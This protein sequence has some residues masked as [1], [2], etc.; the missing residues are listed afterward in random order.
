MPEKIVSSVK[1]RVSRI[2]HHVSRITFFILLISAFILLV[3]ACS[4]GNDASAQ[5]TTPTPLPAT[6]PTPTPTSP[7]PPPQVA[8]TPVATDTVSPIIVQRFPRRGEELQPDGSIELTF[9]RAM[10]Q[11][12]TAGAF[13]LQV[14]AAPPQKVD[15]QI[16]W[17]D[18]QGRTMRFTP[19]Q[20]LDRATVYDA[21]LTQSA[22]AEDGAPLAE[23]FTF[24]FSTPG[25]LEV[26]QVM[27]A[28]GTTNV[29]T[30]ATITVMFNRPVVA[31]TS[32]EQ[33]ENFP[34][35]LEFEPAVAGT[36]EWLNTSIYVFKPEKPMSGGT[37]FKVRVSPDLTDAAGQTVMAG[38][39]EWS[40][41]TQPPEVVFVSPTDG[42]TLVPI[43]TPVRVTFNQPVDPQS[44]EINFSLNAG[45]FFGGGGV[46]GQFQVVGETLTFTPT[47]RLEFDTTYQVTLA[48]GITSVAG[49]QGMVSP[50]TFSFTTVPLPK[51]VSTEPQNGERAAYPYTD[52]RITFNTPISPATVMPH[53]SMIP[54]L[55]I[56]PTEVYTY[57]SPWDNTFSIGF[58]AKPSTDYEVRIT[59]GIEDPY[60][61]KTQENLTVRFRTAPLPPTYQ[62]RIPDLI[63]TYDAG[64]AARMIVSYVNLTDLNLR[65]FRL[66]PLLIQRP[67]WE[68]NDFAPAGGDLVREWSERLEAAVDKQSFHTIDLVEGGGALEPGLY[69]LEADSPQ[70]PDDQYNDK[71]RHIMVVSET[72]LTLKTGQYDTLVW[73]TNLASG[74]PTPGLEVTFFDDERS[75]L[76]TATTDASGVARLDLGKRDNR[77]AIL[78]VVLPDAN[79]NGFTAVAENW[80]QGISPYDFGLNNVTYGLPQYTAHIYTDRPIY[81]PGQTV[82]FK[83]I[84]RTEDD[85]KFGRPDL[86]QVHLIVRN[87]NYETI[88]DQ[89]MEVSPAG[90]LNGEVKLEDGAALGSYAI[91]IDFDNQ[92]FE[93][94]FQ[95]SAYRAPEFE[96]TV[97]P[98]QTEAKRG[99]SIA[100]TI[101]TSY[102]FGGPLAGADVSWNILAESYRFD[103]AQLGGYSFDDTDDPYVCFDCWWWYQDSVPQPVLSGSGQSDASG[104]LLIEVDGPELDSLLT[105]GS[106]KI[107][108]EATATGLDNQV[109]SGRAEVILHKGDYY[110]GLSPQEYV[111]DAGEETAVDLVAVDWDANRLPAKEL[112][113]QIIRYEWVNTF[114]AEGGGGYWSSETKTELVDEFTVTTD[115]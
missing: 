105:A 31:L 74:Q 68:W 103:P 104:Q 23:P 39:F 72:N 34:Q 10:D 69:Y 1:C 41:T 2:T 22:T 64:L 38:A 36:G 30:D 82:N 81:R 12:A 88:V 4:L 43:E 113:V 87:P 47:E 79:G 114:V 115:S 27:P 77:S 32:L 111:A 28:D 93:H 8:Y 42:Q 80:A 18:P 50:Y 96:V 86:R 75:R 71:Q 108:I 110:S 40:F 70:I 92:Y 52:F 6:S 98:A 49:G 65:L 35:P 14:A 54:P 51:I 57:Y 53:I 9:D 24:R 66:D 11:A 97:D 78:A 76:G 16:T 102:F 112:D 48:A 15:G 55:P 37:T 99:E 101:N 5:S 73:A 17:P 3:P 95:V 90:T 94:Y 45:G 59:P 25:Y 46:E 21:I 19:G 84:L 100:A 7:P 33:A 26:T 91:A 85:V 56:T 44:V 58:G 67:Y 106:Q 83:T 62:L 63:G 61:N 20:P 13:T 29:E 89:M 109:I 60:G 107:I